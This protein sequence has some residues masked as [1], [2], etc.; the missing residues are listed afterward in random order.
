MYM[1]LA[2]TYYTSNR[3][4]EMLLVYMNE[5]HRLGRARVN[6]LVH[7]GHRLHL[8]HEGYRLHGWSTCEQICVLI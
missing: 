4:R 2:K 5:G 3:A 7:E 1:S 6:N 8:I